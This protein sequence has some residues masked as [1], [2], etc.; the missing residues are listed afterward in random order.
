MSSP[1]SVAELTELAARRW[2]PGRPRAVD[3]AVRRAVAGPP[4]PAR[5][6]GR[7]RQDRGRQGARGGARPAT[8]P[9]AVLRGHRHQP[10]AVRV[11]LRAPDAADPGAVRA[12]DLGERRGGR[13]AVRPEVPA[14][15]AAAGGGPGRR[16]GRPA[17]RRDRPGRRRVRGVPARDAVRLPDHHPG[18]RHDRGAEHAAAGRAHLQPHPRAA[19]RAQTAL[20]VPLGRLPGP[21]REVEI[22]LVREPGVSEALARKVVAAVNRLREL[23]LAKPPGVAETIDWVRTLDVLGETDAGRAARVDDTLGRGRQGARRPGAGPRQPRR[24]R[25]A[26]A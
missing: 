12:R 7:G 5:G 13:Q 11:G 16:P 24:D 1:T 6:R 10:G 8:D 22:V 14:G 18:D 3:G 26:G 4:A 2:L 21:E 20:P 15:A 17:D 25:L 23:D 9:A 19:R